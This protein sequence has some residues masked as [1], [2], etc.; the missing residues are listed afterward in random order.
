[1]VAMHGPA[2]TGTAAA[3]AALLA[4]AA[5]A[6]RAAALEPAT[7]RLPAALAPQGV[8]TASASGRFVAH[9]R[10]VAENVGLLIWAEE[11]ADR[12]GNALGVDWPFAPGYPLRFLLR[13]EPERLDGG[14]L[15]RQVLQPGGMSQRVLLWNP[16]RVRPE[17]VHAALV[18][19]LV[20][21]LVLA[22]QPPAARREA[23]SQ[24]PDWFAAG[25]AQSIL[26]GRRPLR[27]DAFLARWQGGASAGLGELL[28]ADDPR[29]GADMDPDACGLL[30]DWLRSRGRLPALTAAWTKRWA[31]GERLT[32]GRL[33]ADLGLPDAR[34]AVMEWDL[35]IAARTAALSFPGE[36]DADAAR[37][38][39]ARLR[40]PAA[41]LPETAGL[42]LP[43]VLTPDT[44][45]DH[46]G[47][48]WVPA[49][50]RRM[51]L[52]LARA[53]RGRTPAVRA[54]AA[55]YDRVLSEL[56]RPPP[57]TRLARWF[58]GPPDA[59]RLRGRLGAADDAVTELARGLDLRERYLDEVEARAD[60]P[61][62]P[63]AAGG[64]GAPEPSIEE[65]A[66]LLHYLDTLEGRLAL[67]A[68]GPTRE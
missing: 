42:A 20:D 66:R 44:L 23:P 47:E 67:P 6:R 32:P 9:G 2:R 61:P 63:G 15:R 55:G 56:A 13:D 24:A 68:P 31:R 16:D 59:E 62:A 12:L 19:L 54:A 22:R 11:T 58:R 27:V 65:R 36:A 29:D 34:R 46:A 5:P 49:A 14:V 1:M 51:R 37:A 26:P 60:A 8:V 64:G 35:W 50:A 38:L 41:A 28:G 57:Q 25:L 48:D 52:A 40:L 45:V 17:D 53:A 18:A 30:V 3:L 21:R 7:G 43:A 10:T 4:A 39:R 33:A